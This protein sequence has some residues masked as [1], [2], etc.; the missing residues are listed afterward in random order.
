MPIE[1]TADEAF[2]RYKAH[3][4]AN[5]LIQGS[6]HG[7]DDGHGRDLACGLG[8]LDPKLNGPRDCPSS[9]MPRWLA[10]M[11]PWFF[12]NQPLDD[13]K[14]WGLRFY[15][16]LKRLKGVV[17]FSVIHDWQAN[18]VGPLAIECAE[19]RGGDSAVHKA[20]AE[21]QWKAL[22]G[23]KFTTDE[24]RPVL[25]AAF[26]EIYIFRYRADAYAAYAYAAYAAADADA[27]AADAAD[28]ADAAAYSADADADAARDK[29]LA[30]CA[31]LV[32]G[33]IPYS[34]IAKAIKKFNDQV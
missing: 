23:Q 9:V 7:G 3:L 26:Y 4:D 28:A 32:R 21:M 29:A 16:E 14:D 24:W 8:A 30:D 22:T 18:V 20:L 25:K 2:D 10:Q 34:V 1:L 19:K 27:Y 12:D 31:D 11:V 17:P 15:A 13:A 6:W 33:V 5:A